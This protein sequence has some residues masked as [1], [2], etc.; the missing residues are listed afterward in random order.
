MQM[1]HFPLKLCHCALVPRGRGEYFYIWKQLF[2]DFFIAQ[3]YSNQGASCRN[4][5]QRLLPD[6]V[7]NHNLGVIHKLRNHFLGSR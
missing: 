1:L 7:M 6:I 5:G 4:T 3:K 2:P